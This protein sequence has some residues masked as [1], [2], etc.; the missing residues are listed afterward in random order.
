MVFVANFSENTTAKEFR[1]SAN[2]CQ[3]YE[4]VY[5]CTVVLTHGL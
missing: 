3:G 5:S 1:K 4:R 2:I